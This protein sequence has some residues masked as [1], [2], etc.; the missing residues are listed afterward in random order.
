MSEAE[1]VST[2]TSDTTGPAA[3]PT[4][5]WIR[6]LR[7]FGPLIGV[8]LLLGWVGQT[9]SGYFEQFNSSWLDLTR[10]AMIIATIALGVNILQGYTGLL[11]LGH[12][13]FF[14]IGG[15]AGAVFSP[16]LLSAPWVP[17][18]VS[19]NAGWYGVVF[20]LLSGFVLG[21]LLALMCVHLRGFY[22]TVVTWAFNALAIPAIVI[23][24]PVLDNFGGA[25][26]RAVTEP[27]NFKNVPSPFG[28]GP[29]GNAGS[30]QYWIAMVLLLFAIFVTWSLVRT[31]WGR[32]FMAIRESELAAKT[33]GVNTYWYKVAAFALSAGIVACAGWLRAEIAQQAGFGDQATSQFES[34]RYVTYVVIGGAGTILG[35]IMAAAGFT[36]GLGISWFQDHLLQWTTFLVGILGLNA[37]VTAPEGGVGN[38]KRQVE[39]LT[40]WRV[41]RGHVRKAAEIVDVPDEFKLPH[42]RPEL[43]G[44]TVL[45]ASALTKLF[46]G[47]AALNEVDIEIKQGTIHALIGPNG[48][49][50]STFVNVITG[51]YEPSRGSISFLGDDFV[52]VPVNKRTSKGVARTFQNL[53]VWR[54]M[55]VIE[56]VM[57][58]CHSWTHSGLVRSIATCGLSKEEK[59]IKNRAWGM[60]HFVGLASKGNQAAGSL[61]FADLRRLEIARALCARPALLC[62]DEPAAGLHPSE[63]TEFIELVKKVR[64][65]GITVLLIE[66]HMDVVMELSDTVTVLDHGEKIAEG[67]PVDIQRDPVVI[68][69]YLGTEAVH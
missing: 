39:N 7:R 37:V 11:S 29:Q 61:T 23:L 47:L 69:A 49:G 62:L 67:L 58:G 30:G 33:Y 15:Y 21:S 44:G 22:L 17:D 34:F 14:A 24:P 51:L 43:A 31:R 1:A 42:S 45:K 53:Q 48:S 55:S 6:W 38:L 59:E 57:V 68:E 5:G 2:S 60:L 10:D 27:V 56:N 12:F 25:S 32:A 20:A 13:A 35:P 66:H 50:K 26:G 36:I 41:K 16:Y 19:R 18:F 4:A 65:A 8:I 52:D 40:L 28:N 46:G 64:E 9:Q 63:I 54:R 3:R